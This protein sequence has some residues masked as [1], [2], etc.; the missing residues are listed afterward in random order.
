MNTSLP[1]PTYL[2]LLPESDPQWAA[3]NSSAYSYAY[4]PNPGDGYLKEF[5]IV[6]FTKSHSAYRIW[7]GPA[8]ECGYWW[9]LAPA[10]DCVE[11]CPRISALDYQDMFAVCPSWNNMTNIT[12]VDIPVNTTGVVGIGQSANCSNGLILEPSPTNLQLNGNACESSSDGYDTCPAI[13]DFLALSSCVNTCT[14]SDLPFKTREGAYK[15]ISGGGDDEDTSSASLLA[16]NGN[17]FCIIMGLL[18]AR[19]AMK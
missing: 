8:S 15:C 4:G 10:S 7:G 16:K 3:L 18:V 5:Q 17:V 2:E 19:F 13:Q 11:V 12:V 9:A 6:V 14:S 1:L